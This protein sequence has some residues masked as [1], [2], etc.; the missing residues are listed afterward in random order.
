MHDYEIEKPFPFDIGANIEF[1]AYRKDTKMYKAKTLPDPNRSVHWHIS[2]YRGTSAGAVHWYGHLRVYSL[3]IELIEVYG[4]E[5]KYN[6]PGDRFSTNFFP[7]TIEKCPE[8]LWTEGFDVD[9]TY[10]RDTDE[11]N[12]YEKDPILLEKKG[13][14]SSRFPIF[15][16]L[17]DRMEEELKRLFKPPWKINYRYSTNEGLQILRKLKQGDI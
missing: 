6:K 15:Y 12:P 9:I 7:E 8:L 5:K 1:V 11:E 2:S 14:H 4:N 10:E 3:S 13:H 16:V 17:K